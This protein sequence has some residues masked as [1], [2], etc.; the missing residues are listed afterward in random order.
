MPL[1]CYEAFVE[2]WIEEDKTR[3]YR[4]AWIRAEI[5]NIPV[6]GITKSKY[7]TAKD[8]LEGGDNTPAPEGSENALRGALA[9][10][11]KQA[12]KS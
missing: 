4:F 8:L 6:Y 2:D 1:D 9:F 5:M 7:W 3:A 12:M 11:G 10:A